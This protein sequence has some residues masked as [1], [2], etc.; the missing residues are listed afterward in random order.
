MLP[1]P[2]D[3]LPLAYR[4]NRCS[5]CTSLL[6][7]DHSF[8][9]PMFE[10]HAIRQYYTSSLFIEVIIWSL[11]PVPNSLRTLTQKRGDFDTWVEVVIICVLKALKCPLNQ[12]G[13]VF[14][15]EFD[16]LFLITGLCTGYSWKFSGGF[17]KFYFC[18][19]EGHNFD[20]LTEMLGHRYLLFID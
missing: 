3:S 9:I 7:S 5:L 4:R 1:S 13:S 6:L 17:F 14:C 16:V 8:S 18:T 20:M 11:N 19:R 15:W 2:T 10:I 12:W